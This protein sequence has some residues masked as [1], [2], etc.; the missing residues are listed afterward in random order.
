MST[1][2][3]SPPSGVPPPE[4]RQS[5]CLAPLAGLF[6]IV[7]LLPGTCSLLFMMSSWF[8]GQ[9]MRG[10]GPL[11]VITFFIAAGGIALIGFALRNSDRP[12]GPHERP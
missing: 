2:G 3:E 11:W 10:L 12:K 4:S 8:G 6:G 5:G 9:A 7:L 1:P